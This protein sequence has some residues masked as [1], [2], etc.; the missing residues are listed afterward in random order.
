MKNLSSTNKAVEI[1]SIEALVLMSASPYMECDTS[2]DAQIAYDSQQQLDGTAGDDSLIALVGDNVLN[3]GAGNDELTSVRGQNVL[4]GGDG[5]DT[6][7][8][9]AN[10]AEFS[11][12][13]LDNGTLQ[14]STAKRADLLNDIEY[15]QFDDGT[16]TVSDLLEPPTREYRTFDGTGNNLTNPDLGSTDEQLLRLATAE[17]T[18]QVSAP[19]GDNRPSAREVS[20]VIVAEEMAVENSRGLTDLAWLWGQFVDHDIDL[21]EP[22]H[23]EE[24]FNIPVPEGDPQFDP[25]ATGTA[26][27]DLNR[28]AFDPDTGA[29]A[30]DPREQVN[31]ITAFVDGSMI[32]G[33]DSERAAA[34]RTFEGGLLK[35]SEGD[36]LPFNEAGL[37][38]A[39]GDSAS[40]FLAGDIRANEN[41][42][43]TSMHTL[44]VREH[45]RIA[46]DIANS[47]PDLTDEEIYQQ[48]R[49]IVIGEVQAITYNEF[50]P[51]I[52]G[53]SA[54]PEY[55]GYDETTDPGIAN[56]FSTAA[57][58]F[59]HTMLTSQLLRLNNDGSVIDAG[60]LD[61]QRAFF[62]PQE[63]TQHGI[64]SI[65]LGAASKEASEIDNMIV[66][67]VR[68]FLFG[69]PGA[70]GFDLASLNIQRG[71]DHGLADYNQ[72]RTDLGLA[73]VNSFAEIS[74][75][76]DVQQKLAELYDTVNDI[77]LWVGGLAEDHVPGS[78]LGET[79][80]TILIDQFVRLRD[81]DRFWYENIFDGQK[82]AEIDS[83]TL[84][85]VIER[86]T[87]VEHLQDDVFFVY[88]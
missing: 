16:Y 76:E 84:A 26:E 20:N 85:D 31:Q 37:P 70:G 51:A 82:L 57:Y 58:R 41:A 71:R 68:N 18:D 30:D 39:G 79:F 78:S 1:E 67:D 55:Y 72:V 73:P 14:V 88:A 29:G 32:Y 52:L 12:M 33:S 77:D 69:P 22:A 63:V 40:L 25:M 62:A 36:L 49:E 5:Q 23:P 65:L 19:A 42:A 50:L 6:A 27:I 13:L 34:L 60:N 45:N 8:Y 74:S 64:D 61:L 2:P 9:W 81:G 11:I 7:V 3:G 17:Y 10:R 15:L 83:T 43:L 48:T 46:T 59:G 87:T 66:D 24:S 75:D 47:T 54:I 44:W 80:R 28:S 56:E 21:T 53:E 86:N 35:T 4:N 38:N